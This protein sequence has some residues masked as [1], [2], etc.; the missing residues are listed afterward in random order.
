MRVPWAGADGSI[1]VN[2]VLEERIRRHHWAAKN[3][4]WGCSEMSRR[5]SRWGMGGASGHDMRAEVPL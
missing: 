4:L 1:A 3:T 5:T 2:L